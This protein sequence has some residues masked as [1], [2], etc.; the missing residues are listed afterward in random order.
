VTELMIVGYLLWAEIKE[1]AGFKLSLRCRWMEMTNEYT[2][3]S[4]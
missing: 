3:P 2:R 1:R 4:V